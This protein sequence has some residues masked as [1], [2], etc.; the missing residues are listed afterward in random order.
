MDYFPG[1]EG[2]LSQLLLIALDKLDTSG[3]ELPEIA[4]LVADAAVALVRGLDLG[5]LA[6]VHKGTA[7]AV[8]SIGFFGLLGG[9]GHCLSRKGCL[10]D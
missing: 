7:V 5:Q 10:S 4:L 2:V 3:R 9:V 6:L 1:Q 8:T